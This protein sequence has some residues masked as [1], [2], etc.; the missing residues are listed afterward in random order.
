MVS[1][2]DFYKKNQLVVISTLGLIIRFSFW[3]F[4]ANLYYDDNPYIFEDSFS[5]TESILNFIK[6]GSYTYDLNNPNAFAGRMPLYPILWGI[7]Y[8]IFG[9][10]LVYQAVAFT[11]IILDT[12]AIV[13][14]G[15]TAERLFN[16]KTSL[17]TAGLY[18]FYPFTIVWTT[19]SGTELFATFMT[20]FY[21]HLLIVY[22][23]KYK[24]ILLGL[25]AGLTFYSRVY[26][27]IIAPITVV[28]IITNAEKFWSTKL[29][30][31]LLKFILVFTL[32]YSIWP[33]RNYF[34][35][36]KFVPFTTAASGYRSCDEDFISMRKWLYAWGN[37]SE[38]V[39]DYFDAIA[40]TNQQ[41]DFPAHIFQSESEKILADTIVGL[42]RSCGSSFHYW[43]EFELLDKNCNVEIVLGFNTLRRSFIDNQKFAYY[44]RMPLAN[45]KKAIFKTRMTNDGS[46]LKSIILLYRSILV[47]FGF[48]ALF[49]Y[50][51]YR[52]ILAI[53]LFILFMYFFI[54]CVT[55]QLQMRYLIQADAMLLI[56]TAR[57]LEGV[58]TRCS[59]G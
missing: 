39:N 26:L 46:V 40:R 21:F 51:R 27:G 20:I 47:C 29:S 25:T 48:L 13:L 12:V 38:I 14:M 5:F 7:H 28:Y 35:S 50:L 10:K 58:W 9:P 15:R 34:H 59:K 45:F 52:P 22:K 31:K 49:Y 11:Q 19:I 24:M 44:T 36:S 53:S 42:C 4:G 30:R 33:I 57:F 2:L 32:I 54:C 8:L 43:K 17:I 37:H 1:I 56:F 18:A 16:K 41:I 6:N 3:A 55:R 23:G